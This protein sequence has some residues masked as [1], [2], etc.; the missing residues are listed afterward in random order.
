MTNKIDYDSF[1]G[2]IS[3]LPEK[4]TKRDLITHQAMM[5]VSVDDLANEIE[6]RLYPDIK[7]LKTGLEEFKTDILVNEL[8]I[9]SQRIAMLIM[10]SQN[11]LTMGEA[12]LSIGNLFGGAS[13]F[14]LDGYDDNYTSEMTGSKDV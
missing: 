1:V 4:I 2:T 10:A 12:V 3:A 11:A 14:Q 9:R 13:M 5:F 6:N 7:I 8:T